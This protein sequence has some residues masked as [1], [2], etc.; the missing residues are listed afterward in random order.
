MNVF[1]GDGELVAIVGPSGIGKSTLLR[2]LGGFIKPTSGE[3]RLMGKKVTSPTP[4]IALIHQSIATFPWLT[5][6]DNVKLGLK[7]KKL[8]KEEEDKI[9][10]KMLEVV[11]LQGFENFYPKQMSGGMRQRVAIARALAADPLVLLMDEPFSHLDEL[12]AEG[13]R[14]E[15]YNMIFNEE[16]SL[17]SAVLVSH[18][19]TEVLELSDRIFVLN[20]R[21]A[22][23]VGEIKVEMERP[24]N[25]KSKEFQQYL[26]ELYKLLT[27]IPKKIK[28]DGKN[29]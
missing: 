7:Y 5:A 21:P 19:L 23:V 22:S 10:R 20:N 15:V 14:Q 2:I 18:N 29:D 16:T 24:R 12:T 9:A 6:L 28:E 25:P 13:L 8:S 4:K 17:R 1:T 27:P 11:G 3:V 26:D